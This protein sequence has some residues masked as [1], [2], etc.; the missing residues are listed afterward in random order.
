MTIRLITAADADTLIAIWAEYRTAEA[1]AYAL[2]QG[3]TRAGVAKW[4]RNPDVH[5]A[6]DPATETVGVFEVHRPNMGEV[7]FLGTRTVAPLPARR[8]ADAMLA[9]GLRRAV[10]IGITYAFGA[11]TFPPGVNVEQLRAIKYFGGVPAVTRRTDIAE[12]GNTRVLFETS[13]IPA[14]IAGVEAR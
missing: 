8:A 11:Y 7:C 4:L 12:N 1:A 14:V 6:I 3:W 2:E 5:L 13:D 9:W 10:T